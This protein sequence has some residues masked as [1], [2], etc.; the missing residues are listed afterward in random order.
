MNISAYIFGNFTNGFTQYPSDYT[1]NIFT[2][3]IS[4]PSC[5]DALIT[6]RNGELIYYAYWRKI[7]DTQSIGF[8]IILNGLMI[9]SP[10][11]VF[12]LFESIFT[13]VLMRGDLIHITDNGSFSATIQSLSDNI[14]ESERTT[15][16]II[17]KFKN[18]SL[19][20][21]KLPSLSFGH[22]NSSVKL[23]N[24]ENSTEE[25][26]DAISTY[27][28]TIISRNNATVDASLHD[29]ISTIKRLNNEKQSLIKKYDSLN[30]DFTKL[31]KQK[32][33][34]QLVTTLLII[35]LA[36]AISLFLLL[37]DLSS[38]QQELTET[39][40]QLQSAETTI[41]QYEREID[42]QKNSI[43]VLTRDYNSE[44]YLRKKAEEKLEKLEQDISIY[45][46]IAIT[47]IEIGNQG[48]NGSIINNYGGY[49]YSSQ[50]C[51]LTPRISYNSM[52]DGNVDL[53]VKLYTPFG[54]STTTNSSYSYTSSIYCSKG[55]G[56]S[57][58][59]GWGSDKPGNW[60]AGKYRF[61]FWNG[62]YCLGS[63]SFVI[64]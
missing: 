55:E 9:T 47:E 12:P 45:F 50:T 42:S 10:K 48:A 57:T 19:I 51:Y 8:C 62:N 13:N 31:H 49:I 34:V 2:K 46:P 53:Y 43:S 29:Y 27:S 41:S 40:S 1:K 39:T 61:E 7:T 17:S 26:N 11:K 64:H 21:Q 14:Y 28:Y 33:Q 44:Q 5:E 52:I 23:L 16:S 18:A 54:L 25:L 4:M 58:L 3:F 22:D 59:S 15:E 24:I 63:K 37:G 35:V 38:T 6:H 30:S 60:K 32:K 20:T 56:T 36:G